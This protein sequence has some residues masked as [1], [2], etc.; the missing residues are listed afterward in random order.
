MGQ[1]KQDKLRQLDL[2]EE[3]DFGTDANGSATAI[4]PFLWG[5]PESHGTGAKHSDTSTE[6]LPVAAGSGVG[7]GGYPATVCKHVWLLYVGLTESYE[8]CK[9]CDTRRTD[10][11]ETKCIT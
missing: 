1:V 6:D 11:E 2:L 7:F 5:R 10:T 8:Y 4:W 3:E 9:H